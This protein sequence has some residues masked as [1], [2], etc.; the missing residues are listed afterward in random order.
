[1]LALNHLLA[2]VI[3]LAALGAYGV[4]GWSRFDGGPLSFPSA[5]VV[6]VAVALIWAVFAAP[7]SSNRLSNIFLLPLKVAMF[8]GAALAL[9]NADHTSFAIAFGVAAAVQLVLALMLGVL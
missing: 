6:A 2:F 4:W 8:A 1:M 9:A 7:N 5:L 3:E